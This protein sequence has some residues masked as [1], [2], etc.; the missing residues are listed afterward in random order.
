MRLLLLTALLWPAAG[1]TAEIDIADPKLD[2]RGPGHYVYPNHPIFFRR[3]VFDLRRL[4]IEDAGKDW[5]IEVRIERPSPDPVELRGTP[6]RY[7]RFPNELYFQNFDLYVLTPDAME[8]ELRTDAVPGRNVTFAEG[9]NRAVVITP[10]PFQVRGLIQDWPGHA[11]ASLPGT[12]RTIGPR[13]SVKIPKEFFGPS[14]PREWRFAVI[15]SGA[16]PLTQDYRRADRKHVNAL[17][18][19]VR[20]NPGIMN[21]TGA[22]LSP[23]NPSVIDI[24]APT[25]EAQFE[26]LAADDE[27]ERTKP[28]S[29]RL[30]TA[31]DFIPES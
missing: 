28:V 6:V 25:P 23:F 14:K 31:A 16:I 3:G 15:V 26:E 12:V 17:T 5:S 2:D 27:F 30:R 19:P 20:P 24:L 22:D 9:W 7:V 29:L 21:F 1:E 13:F 4:I 10:Y 11:Q 8:G 18:M